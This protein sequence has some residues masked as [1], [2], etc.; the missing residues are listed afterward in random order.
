MTTHE[1]R[2][3]EW[4]R[5]ETWL[6]YASDQ[7][8]C[9]SSCRMWNIYA[10][11]QLWGCMQSG[12]LHRC[13]PL[14]CRHV[15]T[16][17]G[18]MVCQLT[19]RDHGRMVVTSMYGG[20]IEGRPV[21][22]AQ[23]YRIQGAEGGGCMVWGDGDDE[24][25]EQYAEGA[26]AGAG[27]DPDPQP[28]PPKSGAVAAS[29]SAARLVAQVPTQE[30]RKKRA[31]VGSGVGG[32]STPRIATPK[33]GNAL[34]ADVPDAA[35]AGWARSTIAELMGGSARIAR[36]RDA[37][38]TVM[39]EARSEVARVVRHNRLLGRTTYARMEAAMSLA[40]GMRRARLRWNTDTRWE[41]RVDFCINVI[42]HLWAL[43][44]SSGAVATGG[45]R[46]VFM[47][48]CL[49]VLYDMQ[50]GRTMRDGAV[51]VVPHDAQVDECLPNLTL[52][53]QYLPVAHF[54]FITIGTNLLTN[55]MRRIEDRCSMSMLAVPLDIEV[56]VPADRAS[57]ERSLHAC[58][59]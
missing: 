32:V 10:P 42:M 40:V 5:I 24:C 45:V 25:T 27:T 34:D 20:V 51:V 33:S 50:R 49:A 28:P 39:T 26:G 9:A 4:W 29:G 13:T 57:V 7:H 11:T 55:A 30:R 22:H 8:V 58:S 14:E 37:W 52:I 17:G 19:G 36:E 54:S 18:T 41:S 35:L 38:R 53:H 16:S 6:F 44:R 15:Y 46:V 3:I 47:Q 1:E 56:R 2:A 31:R 59:I 23:Q 43:V 21:D 12:C 48:H